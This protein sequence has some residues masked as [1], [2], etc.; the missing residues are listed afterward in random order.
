MMRTCHVARLPISFSNSSSHP[1]SE[2]IVVQSSRP[3][4]T[5]F[6]LGRRQADCSLRLS[7]SFWNDKDA[8]H[9]GFIPIG[10]PGTFPFSEGSGRFQG[11]MSLWR[12][13][14][15][16]LQVSRRYPL[17]LSAWRRSSCGATP[18]RVSITPSSPV[19]SQSRE[20]AS[21]ERSSMSFRISGMETPVSHCE[22][23]AFVTPHSFPNSL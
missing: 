4:C 7:P 11:I 19:I 2:Y 23:A 18:E 3:G 14:F 21:L 15:R 16:R 12:L 10:Y 20:K 17:R 8:G 6:V 5:W 22:I 1:Q 9:D 13:Y